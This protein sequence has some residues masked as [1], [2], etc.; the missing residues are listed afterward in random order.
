[1]VYKGSKERR[2]KP[3]RPADAKD[4][5]LASDFVRQSEMEFKVIARRNKLLGLWA[6]EMMGMT[7]ETAKEYS[8]EVVVSNIEEPGDD[9]VVRKVMKDFAER[10][11]GESEDQLRQEMDALLGV[12][13][14][15][16]RSESA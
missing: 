12:A 2:K 1:M 3:R 4:K 5:G 13:S 10:G 6:A 8:I 9:G 14:G 15:Q 11:V 16:I 7:G